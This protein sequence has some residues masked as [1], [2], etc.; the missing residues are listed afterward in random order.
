MAKLPI[1][2]ENWSVQKKKFTK[3]KGLNCLLLKKNKKDTDD[4]I[5]KRFDMQTNDES[6]HI[7]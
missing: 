2:K 3:D 4:D 5:Y 1:T 6:W 7:S